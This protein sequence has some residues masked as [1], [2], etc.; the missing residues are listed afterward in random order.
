MFERQRDGKRK[1]KLKGRKLIT[2]QKVTYNR[3]RKEERCHKRRK[4]M[5]MRMRE[6]DG[7]K[8]G[9]R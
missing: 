8:E 3:E 7:V 9:E 5:R 1:R 4:I 6:W 2:R